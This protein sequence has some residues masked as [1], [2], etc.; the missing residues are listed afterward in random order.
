MTTVVPEIGGF[1][2]PEDV[3]AFLGEVLDA[4][5]EFTGAAAGW[6][7]LT[8]PDGRLTFP[9]RRG[10]FPEAWLTLQQGQG[11]PVW[12]FE[13]REGCTLL[14]DSLPSLGEPPLHN[15]LPY[16]LVVGGAPRGQIVLANKLYGFT[17][18]DALVVQ[19]L[20]RL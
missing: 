12:G 10:D 11:N 18:H 17:S 15:L 7:G 1:Q 6:I 4:L 5:L 19:A 14:N 2:G 9:V 16:R 3:A 8:G 13:V 20:A